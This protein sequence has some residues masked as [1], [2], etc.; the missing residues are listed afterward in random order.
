M[1]WLA[2]AANVVESVRNSHTET[3]N[4]NPTDT[5]VLLPK[6]PRRQSALFCFI[7][8]IILISKII[9]AWNIT[10]RH[11]LTAFLNLSAHR[12]VNLQEKHNDSA[13]KDE[14]PGPLT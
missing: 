1:S 4:N 3:M 10:Q 5:A 11:Y 12:I 7:F 2:A 9:S 8:V 14:T 13:R 6:I